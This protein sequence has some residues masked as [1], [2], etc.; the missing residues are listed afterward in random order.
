[1]GYSKKK[2][3]KTKPGGIKFIFFGDLP[4]IT[5]IILYL[6]K[7]LKIHSLKLF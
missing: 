5:A 4:T 3:E 6:E 2:S 7:V 1:L